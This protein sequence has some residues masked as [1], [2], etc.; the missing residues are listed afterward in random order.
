MVS[1]RR[2]CRWAASVYP[3]WCAVA[4][5]LFLRMHDFRAFT[6]V[7]W[8]LGTFPLGLADYL[9]LVILALVTLGTSLSLAVQIV[10]GSVL[11]GFLVVQ[12]V[13]VRVLLNEFAPHSTTG[14]GSHRRKGEL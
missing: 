10:V 5:V 8:L 14:G 4:T 2:V 7:A 13:V 11:L 1:R 3:I 9:L 6:V 12:V